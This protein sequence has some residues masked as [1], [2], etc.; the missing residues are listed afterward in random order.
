MCLLRLHSLVCS[1]KMW[2]PGDG[3][4][5][6]GQKPTTTIFMAEEKITKVR[7]KIRSKMMRYM[8]F[9][10][11]TINLLYLLWFGRRQHEQM[12]FRGL[13]LSQCFRIANGISFEVCAR[14]QNFTNLLG[15]NVDVDA[16]CFTSSV[17]ILWSWTS[18]QFELSQIEINANKTRL[19]IVNADDQ[20]EININSNKLIRCYR[21]FDGL[22]FHLG[23]HSSRIEFETFT[24]IHFEIESNLLFRCH[25]V[26]FFS[27]LHGYWESITVVF[28]HT[29]VPIF[30]TLRLS[31]NVNFMQI[32]ALTT[33]S[34]NF[35]LIVRQ[36]STFY[37]SVW[38]N[39]CK[40]SASNRFSSRKN[41]TRV[42]ESDGT[43]TR[44]TTT[45]VLAFI[46]V[47]WNYTFTSAQKP[48][49]GNNNNQFTLLR[50]A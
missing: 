27:S 11:N 14:L 34:L 35:Y 1:A 50:Y 22:F 33:S 6:T 15:Q 18:V 29:T 45:H 43:V 31:T 19:M 10:R 41:V 30:E 21:I 12:D 16:F 8:G 38:W 49:Q 23:F 24:F 28:W 3:V 46:P 39:V 37:D 13:S 20:S 48:H 9:R 40:I 4:Q 36:S 5:H 26:F 2:C 42:S 44:M 32:V 17:L 25:L 7:N 47:N